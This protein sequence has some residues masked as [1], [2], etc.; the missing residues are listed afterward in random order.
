[1]GSRIVKWHRISY[2]PNLANFS[3]SLPLCVC[4]CACAGSQPVTG[5]E[6]GLRSPFITVV[7][8][9]IGS[10][11]VKE[12]LLKLVNTEQKSNVPCHVP[13]MYLHKLLESNIR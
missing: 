12:N 3:R 1:M 5:C 7:G 2:T 8:I 4:V 11:T 9:D 13:F 6:R 10:R